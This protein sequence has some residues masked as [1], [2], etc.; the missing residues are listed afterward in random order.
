LENSQSFYY[1]NLLQKKSQ[2]IQLQC[3]EI[4]IIKLILVIK[5]K[6]WWSG[7]GVSLHNSIFFKFCIISIMKLLIAFWLSGSMRGCWWWYSWSCWLLPQK[8]NTAYRSVSCCY[9][10]F[11]FFFIVV[12]CSW[13]LYFDFEKRLGELGG[14]LPLPDE[15]VWQTLL[16]CKSM[17]DETSTCVSRP[18]RFMHI[19]LTLFGQTTIGHI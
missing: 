4:Y 6:L 12:Y 2:I 9:S 7:C 1:K 15:S 18:K 11:S 8:N 16:A 17:T 10:F 5:W 13:C 19:R 14:H 3:M